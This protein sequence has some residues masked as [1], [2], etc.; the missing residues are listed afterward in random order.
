MHI[1]N[2][3]RTNALRCMLPPPTAIDRRVKRL[4]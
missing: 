4:L 2:L 3:F 1:M